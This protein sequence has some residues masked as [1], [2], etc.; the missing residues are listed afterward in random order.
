MTEAVWTG[1][2]RRVKTAE[3]NYV[4][5]SEK[6]PDRPIASVPKGHNDAIRRAAIKPHFVLYDLRHKFAT[7]AVA[8]GV[9]LPD[10]ER[11]AGTHL[12]NDDD[13]IRSS[14]SR[15]ETVGRLRTSSRAGTVGRREARDLPHQRFNGG[16]QR[17][18]SG[19]KNGHSRSDKLMDRSAKYLKSLVGAPRFELGTSC[20]QGRRATRL[21][22][23]PT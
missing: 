17:T 19:H 5:P 11:N 15:T 1:L 10:A 23:A 7:R 14:G 4:F 8:A 18:S 12:N 6:H 9:D 20:A 22:Y 3:G 2:K 21:R 16:R 13:A